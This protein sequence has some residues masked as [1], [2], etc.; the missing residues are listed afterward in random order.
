MRSQI[1]KPSIGK[2]RT[3]NILLILL[4][5]LI[6]NIG[7]TQEESFHQKQRILLPEGALGQLNGEIS[8]SYT[9]V[10]AAQGVPYGDRQS[11]GVRLT[12][13]AL[14]RLTFF[15]GYSA[16]FSHDIFHQL[17]IGF[18]AYARDPSDSS[19]VANPDGIP[20]SPV[21]S[22]AFMEVI[23]DQDPG[24]SRQNYSMNLRLPMSP[25]ITIGAG[26]NSNRPRLP[27]EVD[28]ISFLFKFLT[29]K[30]QA[31]Q[32]YSNPDGPEGDLAF[33]FTGGG[34]GDGYFLQPELIL[35]LDQLLTLFVYVRR[36]KISDPEIESRILGLRLKFYPGN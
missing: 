6:S 21:V 30:Y 20:L 31:G 3:R 1:A 25:Q 18:S 16:D 34:S 24:N 13:P 27:Y 17:S 26:I 11:S 19:I 15:G 29:G 12:L 5:T 33:T 7:F 23:Q 35:P 32:N 8:G 10:S 22:I 4:I 9:S 36:E 14:R 28:G 2:Y